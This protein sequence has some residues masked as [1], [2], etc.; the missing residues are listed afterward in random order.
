MKKTIS[1]GLHPFTLEK[2]KALK[3]IPQFFIKYE[4]VPL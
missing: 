1:Y 4:D 3:I 2:V